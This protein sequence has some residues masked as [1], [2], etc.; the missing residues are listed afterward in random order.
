MGRVD[1]KVA[2]ITGGARGMGAAHARMLI[3]EGAKVVIGDILDEQG[4]A[5]AAELGDAARYVH[6]DVTDADQWAAAVNTATEQFG[7]LNVLVN[8]AGISAL[9]KIGEFDMAKWQKCIDVNLTGTFLG[10]QAVVASMREAGSGSIINISSIEGMRGATLLHAYV[11]SKW[12]VRGLTKSAA[13]DLGKDNIRVNTV[14][15]GFIR[16]PMTKYFPDDMMTAPLGRPGQPDEVAT[17]VVFLA[18]DESSFATG[19]EFVVDGGLTTDV[20]HKF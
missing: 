13:I 9:G 6:L 17:F 16:T 14:L 15:P 12:A 2:L 7:L 11:A 1:G 5:L 20:P 10:M 8:N 18:S 19:S 3:A 4:E